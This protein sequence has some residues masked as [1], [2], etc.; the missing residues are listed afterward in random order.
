MLAEQ[1]E[2]EASDVHVLCCSADCAVLGL[3]ARAEQKRKAQEAVAR[4]EPPPR[5]IVLVGKATAAALAAI[6]MVAVVYH[7]QISAV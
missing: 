6:V 4:D 3:T 1:R 7:T 5:P 2:V